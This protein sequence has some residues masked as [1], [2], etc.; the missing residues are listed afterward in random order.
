MQ[1][2]ELSLQKSTLKAVADA[3]FHTA[4]LVQQKVIP[5][6]LEKKKCHCSSTNWHGKNG[7]F[8]TPNH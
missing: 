1:F 7:C 4:T 6:V 5:L 3:R 2:S 8:C